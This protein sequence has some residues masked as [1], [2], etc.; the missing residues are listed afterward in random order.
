M[1]TDALF[2]E[3]ALG[4]INRFA[5]VVAAL[6]TVTLAV[7]ATWQNAA[8]FLA[9]AG[10]G[11]LNYRWLKRLAFQLGGDS[12]QRSKSGLAVLLGLR[13]LLLG[14]AAYVTVKFLGFDVKALLG[15]LFVP[16]AAVIIEVFFELIYARV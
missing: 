11:L 13:Y 5:T 7:G 15:G 2:Y 9:G 1:E 6:G 8:G 12:R 3:K 4:R 10:I 16:V 14:V